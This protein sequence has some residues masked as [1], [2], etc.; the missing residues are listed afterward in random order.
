[1]KKIVLVIIL[2]SLIVNVF[3]YLIPDISINSTSLSESLGSSA[4]KQRTLSITNNGESVSIMNY[5]IIIEEPTV[6]D[7]SGSTFT[8]TETDYEPDTTFDLHLSIYNASSDGEWLDGATLDFPTGV[9]VNSST[10]F[11]GGS[12]GDLI[13]FAGHFA[14]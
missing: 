4:I 2:Y 3:A 5:D 9:I 10:N 14:Q 6:R 7:I 1:M 11:V 13:H 12:G 8:S